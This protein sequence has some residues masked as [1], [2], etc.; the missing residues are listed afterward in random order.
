M[1]AAVRVLMPAA[2]SAQAVNAIPPAPPAEN[3]RVAT[4]PPNVISTLPGQSSRGATGQKI[5][6][7]STM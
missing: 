1:R 2:R 6:R 5:S 7:V 4:T 3:S